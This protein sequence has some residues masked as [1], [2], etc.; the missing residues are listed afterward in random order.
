MFDRLFVGTF[1]ETYIRLC[2]CVRVCVC[3]RINCRSESASLMS[4]RL[5]LTN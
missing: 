3:D 2:I 4:K 5:S 1:S